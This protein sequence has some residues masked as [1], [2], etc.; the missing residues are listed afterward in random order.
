MAN[1]MH[2]TAAVLVY[3]A[4]ITT[5]ADGSAVD[6]SAFH[7]RRNYKAVLTVASQ[8]GTSP[9][10]TVKI[11]ESSTTT[12][13]DFTD[14][15]GAAFTAVTTTGTATETIHFKTIKRYVRAVTTLTANTTQS[16]VSAIL[17]GEERIF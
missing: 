11:Q 1:Q 6:L 4:V 7:N 13:A 14:I 17:I 12:A 3:P 15:T 5:S 16:V 2:L 9:S 10:A 8:A